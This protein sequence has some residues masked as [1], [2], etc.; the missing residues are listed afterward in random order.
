V[1]LNLIFQSVNFGYLGLITFIVAHEAC[2]FGWLGFVSFTSGK[3]SRIWG[4]KAENILK[5][6][7]VAILVFFGFY[8]VYSGTSE[9]FGR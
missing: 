9:F 7:S 1:G 4:E 3:A 6:V 2:D 8:F 5:I